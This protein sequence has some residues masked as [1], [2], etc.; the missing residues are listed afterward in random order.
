MYL[1]VSTK[2]FFRKY[3]VFRRNEQE[4]ARLQ[5]TGVNLV[6]ETAE[7][8]AH[9]FSFEIGASAEDVLMCWQAPSGLRLA[10]M[11]LTPKALEGT[12]SYDGHDYGLAETEDKKVFR[13]LR[14]GLYFGTLSRS[15]GFFGA[16]YDI[17]AARDAPIE[18]MGFMLYCVMV[19]PA[20]CVVAGLNKIK[21][22][23]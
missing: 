17:D 15:G 9:R 5:V 14:D 4:I 2:G 1:T 20:V 18:V 21:K 3:M 8:A 23:R 16:R 10:Q 7:G 11:P 12:V 6:F 13:L 19:Y 22:D